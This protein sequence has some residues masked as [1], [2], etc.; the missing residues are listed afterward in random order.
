[1]EVLYLTASHVSAYTW[2]GLPD[3]DLMARMMLAEQSY[4]ILDPVLY[5]DAVGAAWVA[6]NRLD[7]VHG[8]V[9]PDH[10]KNGDGLFHVLAFG[11][12]RGLSTVGN[13]NRAADPEAHPTA[14]ALDD[15]LAGR[16]AYWQ[17]VFLAKKV[18]DG[19]IPDPTGGAVYFADG[20]RRPRTTFWNK[21]YAGRTVA[22]VAEAIWAERITRWRQERLE[23]MVMG[24]LGR[25]REYIRHE[26]SRNLVHGGSPHPAI[27][28]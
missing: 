12:F 26:P 10:I 13:A 9:S 21:D 14:F 6:V 16:K 8:F 27:A 11:Q 28:D 19:E 17:A 2:D 25:E 24:Q 22:E 23:V 3:W 4:K 1:V 7:P 20:K 18:L 5:L 15:P